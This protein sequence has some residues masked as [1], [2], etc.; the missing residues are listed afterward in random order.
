MKSYMR[1]FFYAEYEFYLSK[2]FVTP[3]L[4]IHENYLNFHI[5]LIISI[6][7]NSKLF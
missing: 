6:F 1:V 7:K 4:F 2:C 3:L 5:R